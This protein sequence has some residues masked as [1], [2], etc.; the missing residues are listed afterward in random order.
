[1]KNKFQKPTNF[2]L[3]KRKKQNKSKQILWR[4]TLIR[5]YPGKMPAET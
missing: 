4:K 2:L 5:V 3:G 1:M